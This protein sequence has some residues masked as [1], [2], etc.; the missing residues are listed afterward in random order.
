MDKKSLDTLLK[1]LR[2]LQRKVGEKQAKRLNLELLHR[3]AK[4]IG[5]FAGDCRQC[6][7]YLQQLDSHVDTLKN[8]QGELDRA[9]ARKHQRLIQGIV[10][11][12]QRKH[13]LV[14]EGYYLGVYLSM[15][16][17]LGFALGITLFNNVIIGLAV[18][19]AG[20]IAL[21]SARDRRASRKERP[22]NNIWF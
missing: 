13:R 8:L 19:I 12:M 3:A 5:D 6:K 16:I 4:R 14:A 11:H 1:D 22:S 17:G 15:G 9:T 7:E 10:A 18:G 20:G 2:R 21:G